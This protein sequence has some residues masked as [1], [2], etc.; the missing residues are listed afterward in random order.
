MFQSVSLI[1]TN[2][3]TS[4]ITFLNHVDQSQLLEF[5]MDKHTDNQFFKLNPWSSPIFHIGLTT[6]WL[7]KT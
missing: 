4:R 5:S 6:K 2:E 1:L 7:T 3:S